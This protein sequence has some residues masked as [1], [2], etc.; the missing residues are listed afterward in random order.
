MHK[1]FSNLSF[2]FIMSTLLKRDSKYALASIADRKDTFR[3]SFFGPAR[4][5]E[6]GNG[7]PA[8]GW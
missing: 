7:E 2:W 5:S 1:V 4:T 3:E 8:G 6:L